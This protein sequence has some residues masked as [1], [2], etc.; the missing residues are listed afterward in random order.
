M[1]AITIYRSLLEE[2]IFLRMSVSVS[3]Q[4]GSLSDSIDRETLGRV[5][6]SVLLGQGSL[7]RG[8]APIQSD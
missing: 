7:C 8:C 2:H 5:S 6:N 1:A 4:V 3:T